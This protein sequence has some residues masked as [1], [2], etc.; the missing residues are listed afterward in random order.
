MARLDKWRSH[1]TIG[2]WHEVAK[3]RAFRFYSRSNEAGEVWMFADYRIDGIVSREH[4]LLPMDSGN[5][6][7]GKLANRTALELP[8][9]KMPEFEAGWWLKP[10]QAEMYT[11]AVAE[12]RRKYYV[13]WLELFREVE[14]KDPTPAESDEMLVEAGV[15]LAKVEPVLLWHL[16]GIDTDYSRIERDI[17]PP[18][19]MRGWNS[20][21]EVW[22][23]HKQIAG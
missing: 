9:E 15:T 10:W 7:S 16:L 13:G 1:S 5:E 22:R 11:Q 21:E 17:S 20:V 4:K 3:D 12:W 6:L 8:L 14:G 2:S 18:S 23:E 19:W